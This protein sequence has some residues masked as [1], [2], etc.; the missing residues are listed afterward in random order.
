MA[1]GHVIQYS[2]KETVE[3]DNVYG[4]QI[5]DYEYAYF[6]SACKDL[7]QALWQK[8][9]Y[10]QIYIISVSGVMDSNPIPKLY[11]TCRYDIFYICQY[12][13]YYPDK[14]VVKVKNIYTFFV[15]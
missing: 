3:Q 4:L 11:L 10:L 6:I 8:T 9:H 1:F 14:R 7:Y 13:K 12:L 2:R 15:G 5:E